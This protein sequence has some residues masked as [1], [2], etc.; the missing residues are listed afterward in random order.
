[1]QALVSTLSFKKFQAIFGILLHSFAW[2]QQNLGAKN[3]TLSLYNVDS[4]LNELT[5]S[6][7]KQPEVTQKQKGLYFAVEYLW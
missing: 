4:E 7:C 6:F 1:M 5:R 2:P 3:K